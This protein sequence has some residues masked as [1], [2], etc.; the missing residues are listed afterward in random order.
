MTRIL[1]LPLLTFS[2]ELANNEDWIDS[3][4]Y[5]DVSS[6]PISLA[7]LTLTMMVRARAADQTVQVVASSASGPVNG[8]PQNGSISSGGT[9]LNVIALAIPRA[10]V[11]KLAPGEYVFEVQASG[12]GVTRNIASGPVIVV[13]GVVR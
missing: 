3:W 13:S 11:A 1:D 5:I 12:D 8:L 6:N 7:G 9:G 10:T 2:V 4:A